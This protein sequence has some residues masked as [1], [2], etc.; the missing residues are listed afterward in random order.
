L[1]ASPLVSILTYDFD[2]IFSTQTE[3]KLTRAY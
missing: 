3:L 2:P 1:A